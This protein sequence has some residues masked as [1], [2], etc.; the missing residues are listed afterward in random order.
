MKTTIYFLLILI[1]LIIL[2]GFGCE[3]IHSI[4]EPDL[5]CSC[6]VK[7]KVDK[8]S[9]DPKDTVHVT[10]HNESNMPVFLEGCSP[11]YFATKMDTGWLE[12]PMCFCKWE[13]YGRK[14]NPNAIYQE[15]YIAKFFRGVHRF[16]APIYFGC[17]EGKPIS[18]AKCKQSTKVYSSKFVVMGYEITAGNL[19]IRTQKSEYTWGPYDLG[20][21]RQIE[22]IFLNNSKET[23]YARLGDRFNSDIDQADLFVAEGSNGFIEKFELDGSWRFMPRGVLIEGTRFVELRPEKSYRLFTY[24]PWQEKETGNFRIK[25][26]YY[27]QIDPPPDANPLIDYSNIFSIK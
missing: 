11:F 13:G 20:S 5:G 2:V 3:R 18:Q 16:V 7:L 9:Y 21:S 14:I 24:L 1:I 12:A 19:S 27:H 23:Y 8:V 6:Q 10:L 25:L 4:L 26:E 15:K 17:L 22:A